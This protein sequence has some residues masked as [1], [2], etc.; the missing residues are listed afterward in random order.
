MDLLQF[1]I[2]LLQWHNYWPS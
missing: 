2:K 1:L